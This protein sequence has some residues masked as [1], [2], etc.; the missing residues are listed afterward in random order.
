[1]NRTKVT[2]INQRLPPFLMSIDLGQLQRRVH[3]NSPG[4]ALNS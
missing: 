4:S 3:E 2:L 1:M